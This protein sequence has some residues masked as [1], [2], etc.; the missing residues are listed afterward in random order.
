M[1]G[2]ETAILDSCNSLIIAN[3]PRSKEIDFGDLADKI[4]ADKTELSSYGLWDITSPNFNTY[5]PDV[6]EDDLTPEDGDFIFPVFRGLSA[7]LINGTTDYSKPGVL[8]AS[9]KLLKGQTVYVN[10]DMIVGAHVGVIKDVKWQEAYEVGSFK[11]PAGINTHLKID[12]KSNPNISRA[13]Q[14]NP[15]AVHSVSVTIQYE[16][17]SS[18]PNLSTDEFWS[19]LGTK[20]NGELVRKVVTKIIRYYEISLVPHGADRFAKILDE[21]GKIIPV[22]I[23]KSFEQN[24][25][26]LTESKSTG[27]SFKDTEISMN[28]ETIP[29]ISNNNENNENIMDEFLAKLALQ[30]KRTDKLTEE[31]ALTELKT[32]SEK[33]EKADALKGQL[34]TA[35]A[36]KNTL[37]GQVTTLTGERDSYKD[38]ADKYNKLVVGMRTDVLANYTKLKGDEKDQ[39]IVNLI[40]TADYDTLVS[41]NKDYNKE[42]DKKYPLSCK[43]CHSTNIDRSSSTKEG[44]E[45]PEDKKSFNR[46]DY[47]KSKNQFNLHGEDK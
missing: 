34:D 15:P 47:F 45:K 42:L 17:E 7:T 2:I 35:N 1:K 25:I 27:I 22:N 3:T 33:A 16:W 28:N 44:E 31:L 11:V 18:H 10:H 29:I 39:A 9:M 40:S 20:V 23:A 26:K 46:E 4:M 41:L 14:M 36:D 38:A 32:L 30:L 5:Y 37:S 21:E 13:I 24:S 6:T 8:K 12:G 43:D 19:K